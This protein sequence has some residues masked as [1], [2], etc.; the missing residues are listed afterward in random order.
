MLGENVINI[1]NSVITSDILLLDCVP[2]IFSGT[3]R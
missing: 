2:L 3:L 1:F